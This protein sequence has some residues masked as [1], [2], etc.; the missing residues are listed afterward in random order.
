MK[1]YFRNSKNEYRE[2][3]DVQ[4]YTEASQAIIKFCTDRNYK[5]YYTRMWI[6]ENEKLG[7]CIEKDVGSW[8][9]FFYI[10]VSSH[11]EGE[12]ILTEK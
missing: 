1:V 7:W 2:I 12:K 11:E 10:P 6:T 8:S 9:E 4:N 3:A 5:V